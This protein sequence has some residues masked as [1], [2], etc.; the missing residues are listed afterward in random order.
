MIY[1]TKI[2]I[3]LSY[4]QEVCMRNTT[5]HWSRLFRYC[6]LFIF[7]SVFSSALFIMIFTHDWRNI[8]NVRVQIEAIELSFIAVIYVAFPF[9]L[10]RFFYYFY[11]LVTHGRQNGIS[12][13]CYQTLFNPFNFLFRPSLLNRNGLTHRRRCI[14]T[15]I[16]ML[17]LY[18][19]TFVMNQIPT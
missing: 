17:C 15:I 8:F 4:T 6:L 5:L 12:L 1:S 10:I 16:L 18:G 7:A 2:Y 14:I 13:F 9:L 11:Q 19:S 3:L